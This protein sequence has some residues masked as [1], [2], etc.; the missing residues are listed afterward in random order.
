MGEEEGERQQETSLPT[1]SCPPPPTPPHARKQEMGGKIN[2]G[3]FNSHVVGKTNFLRIINGLC[4]RYVL[5]TNKSTLH[6]LHW[7]AKNESAFSS[8]Y[9]EM[10]ILF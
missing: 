3:G 8:E 2:E 6:S 10:I 1:S 4:Y 9:N 5:H 7:S